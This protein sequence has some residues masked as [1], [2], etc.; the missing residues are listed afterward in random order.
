[1]A[2][3]A[4]S[5][6]LDIGTRNVVGLLALPTEEGGLRVV[7]VEAAE[8][9]DRSMRDGQVHDVPGVAMRVRRIKQVLEERSGQKLTRAAVAA[10]G[11]ALTTHVASAELALDPSQPI[12]PEQ[13]KALDM[14]AIG[15]ALGALEAKVEPGTHHCVGYSPIR[16]TLDGFT[17][18]HPLGHLGRALHVTLIATF[19]PRGVTD[20]LGTVLR[21]ADLE[22]AN[23]TLEPIAAIHAAVP[24]TMR[25]LNIAL[26]DIGA[27]TS[28]IALTRDSTILGYAMVPMAGDAI[29][30]ALSQRY[31]MDFTDAERLK[32]SL[33]GDS[34]VNFTDILG[35]T[36]TLQPDQVRAEVHPVVKTLAMRI[37]TAILEING[38]PPSAVL[39]VGG[40]SMTPGLVAALAQ[41]LE[42]PESRVGLR[43]AEMVRDVLMMGDRPLPPA[44]VGPA[45]I[46][47]IG[48]AKSA[49]YAPGFRFRDVWVNDRFLQVLDLG[50]ATVLDALVAAGFRAR[51]LSGR[52]GLGLGITLNGQF[53]TIPG[54]PA[55]AARILLEG[56]E[57][58]HDAPLPDH[59]HLVVHAAQDGADARVRVV[60][61]A[62][63]HDLDLRERPFTVN[64][65]PV[66]LH[67][68][69]TLNGQ[70]IDP[71]SD[72]PD[73]GAV[74]IGVRLEDVLVAA[75]QVPVREQAIQVFV[76]GSPVTLPMTQALPW[77]DGRETPLEALL[78][79]GETIETT[80][81]QTLPR[82]TDL[83]QVRTGTSPLHVFLNGAALPLPTAPTVRL[84]GRPAT[85]ASGL[86]HGDRVELG[87]PGE[88]ILADLL[89]HV[90]EDLV[91]CSDPAKQ[92]VLEVDGLPAEFTT[93]VAPGSRVR[94]QWVE[95]PQPSLL[96][97]PVAGI[98]FLADTH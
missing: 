4:P 49:L 78:H 22:M 94:A 96:P 43:G 5:F 56:R 50:N 34:P 76:N 87:A 19:L 70:P 75:G 16:Y 67:P 35:N 47:P 7:D 20:S 10:A 74:V 81:G 40:G 59:A 55:I 80:S 23:L 24:S 33:G 42:L 31:L 2:D 68:K 30:E 25:A 91:A 85:L 98:T 69:V 63:G 54:G 12:S 51:Q 83:P 58:P 86:A 71:G 28:D 46:T 21:W 3:P 14:A 62:N 53:V 26:V 77:V 93:P 52:P 27:G 36:G 18:D 92:L 13:V 29:T 95:R 8:H 73:G 60:E 1:M 64:G 11:R 84:N 48:I 9:P 89:E 79:G 39:L 17:V 38:K 72:V 66:R 88:V 57:I 41:A 15:N 82:I 32:V 61:L 37:A 44:L 65:S 45:G 97:P 90:R 6:V